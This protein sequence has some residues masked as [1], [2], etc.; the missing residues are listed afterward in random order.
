MPARKPPENARLPGPHYILEQAIAPPDPDH[1]RN[2]SEAD[3]VLRQRKQIP[4][5]AVIT[6]DSMHS[7]ER[8]DVPHWLAQARGEEILSSTPAMPQQ[9][10]ML[11]SFL[12]PHP[13]VGQH[14]FGN[15]ASDNV[16]AGPGPIG[17]YGHSAT[18]VPGANHL[19]E[20]TPLVYDRA[21]GQETRV[22]A[23]ERALTGPPVHPVHP[24]LPLH[25]AHPMHPGHSAHPGNLNANSNDHLG[26]YQRAGGKRL[27]FPR[28]R[29]LQ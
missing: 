27:P 29:S 13:A 5:E 16:W 7:D 17:I 2:R 12:S 11:Q 20:Y 28:I 8:P 6:S 22:M 10:P 4:N 15:D 24:G 14:G 25:P 19:H 26:F 23:L 1:H 21:R 3:T 9:S 18:A